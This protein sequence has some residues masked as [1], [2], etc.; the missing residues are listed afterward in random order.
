MNAYNMMRTGISNPDAFDPSRWDKTSPD[1]NRYDMTV[2]TPC[3]LILYI[4]ISLLI[5]IHG[6]LQEVFIP[7][8][9]GR[10][11]CIGMNLAMLETKLAAATILRSF[12]FERVNKGDIKYTHIMTIFP[13]DE[14]IHVIARP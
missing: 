5:L 3:L 2:H 14:Y 6:R 4:L 13:E 11:N 10:R 1:Y 12:T 7:F 8:S 9:L